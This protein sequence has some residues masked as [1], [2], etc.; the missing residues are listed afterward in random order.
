MGFFA[1]FFLLLLI[2]FLGAIYY[3]VYSPWKFSKQ[4][5]VRVAEKV[6]IHYYFIVD[7][8]KGKKLV[9]QTQPFPHGDPLGGEESLSE[10]VT[11]LG[12]QEKAHK[13]N[14]LGK[15]IGYG[16][17]LGNKASKF[18]NFLKKEAGK[19]VGDDFEVRDLATNTVYCEVK[20]SVHVPRQDKLEIVYNGKV[21][22]HLV[23]HIFAIPHKPTYDVFKGDERIGYIEK[24]VIDLLSKFEFHATIDSEDGGEGEG[25]S[26]FQLR[27]QVTQLL[28]RGDYVLKG[29]GDSR[30]YLM[31]NAKG[32]TV[33]R[34]QM[35]PQS[36]AEEGETEIETDTESPD[37]QNRKD[38]YTIEVA[39]GMDPILVL[40]F[41]CVVDEEL[42]ELDEKEAE[43]E[44]K[45]KEEA[46]KEN[47]LSS[48]GEDSLTTE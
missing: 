16:G 35:S 12:I 4:D 10:E 48:Q 41:V 29:D 43:A 20:N 40:A 17:F 39:P 33:A 38:H 26:P 19:F 25:E 34:I 6:A 8:L 32:Q 2:G 45:A 21:V 13:F 44:E 3:A 28:K 31:K 14:V 7:F 23:Q 22:A 11:T 1:T 15:N 42:D 18:S 46:E 24:D 47:L 5:W 37:N 30:R 36:A 27:L 9:P